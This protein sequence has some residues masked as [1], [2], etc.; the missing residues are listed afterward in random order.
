MPFEQR[1][2][3]MLGSGR[4]CLWRTELKGQ[5]EP[6]CAGRALWSSAFLLT[7]AA[8]QLRS[9]VRAHAE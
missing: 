9:T 8:R 7:W 3:C 2:S 6:L 1:A 4:L 5:H